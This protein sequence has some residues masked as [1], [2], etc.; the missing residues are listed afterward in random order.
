M[1]AARE[2][3]PMSPGRTP[4]AAYLR[5]LPKSSPKAL[6]YGGGVGGMAGVAGWSLAVAAASAAST[7][8]AAADASSAFLASSACCKYTLLTLRIQLAAAGP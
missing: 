3:T 6:S 8:A 5:A 4:I 7:A 2:V 1:S